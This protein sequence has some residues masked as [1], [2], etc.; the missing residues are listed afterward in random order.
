MKKEQMQELES[1]KREKREQ[2]KTHYKTL[3]AH[4]LTLLRNKLGRLT[5][6]NIY[7]LV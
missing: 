7:T 3:F 5:S 4:T 1:L 6:A 2:V